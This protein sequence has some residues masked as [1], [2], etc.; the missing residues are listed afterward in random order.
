[1]SRIESFV[2]PSPS[3]K[4][5][6]CCSN[7]Y[8]CYAKSSPYAIL[9]IQSHG[10]YI[11]SWPLLTYFF[12]PFTLEKSINY[13]WFIVGSQILAENTLHRGA[14]KNKV[15]TSFPLEVYIS[16]TVFLTCPTGL[17]LTALPRL[18]STPFPTTTPS[19]LLLDKPF[20]QTTE[21]LA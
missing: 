9:A 8:Q 1:M 12:I 18:P 15:Y 19:I 14:F 17:R 6:T 7:Q 2:C 3:M 20:F 21:H 5:K 4:F 10:L 13:W 11:F 16:S